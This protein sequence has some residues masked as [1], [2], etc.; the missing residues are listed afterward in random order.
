MKNFLI[1][2]FIS[3]NLFCY[4]QWNY[5]NIAFNQPRANIAFVDSNS[6]L[7][8]G[9]QSWSTGGTNVSIVQLAH[10]YNI[11]TNQSSILAMNTPRLEPIMV[12]GDSGIYIIG[13]V[14]NWG[15]VN[16]TG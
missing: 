1:S 16:G 10:L 13:G 3:A 14:S 11:S 8:A 15:D 5:G 7:V 6:F 12:R 9:G 4:S 2:I